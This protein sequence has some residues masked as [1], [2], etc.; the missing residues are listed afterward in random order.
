MTSAG[1]EIIAHRGASDQAPENTL[2]AFRRAVELGADG[3][4]LDIQFTADRVPVVHHD[5]VLPGHAGSAPQP[6]HLLKLA[7]VRRLSD[8]PRLDEVIEAV[9]SKTRLYVEIKDP[10]ALENVL[11][12]LGRIGQSAAIHSFDHQAIA[13][14]ARAAPGIRRGVLLVSRLVN[15]VAAMKAAGATDLW[16]H[17]DKVDA[18]L[19]KL[20]HRAGGRVI[21][22]T[23]NDEDRSVELA[24]LGV[25][26]LCT[27]RPGR[28]IELLRGGALAP[29]QQPK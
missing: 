6:I 1:P 16:Q 14:A 19:V 4:E 18:A 27:D 26:G 24:R 28:L 23:V 5:A 7:D 15:P 11:K 2:A 17:V 13:A 8:V 12:Q 9:G 25:D 10:R 29:P 21:A 20:V 22:W 3:I